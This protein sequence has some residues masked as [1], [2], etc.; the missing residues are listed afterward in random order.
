MKTFE[1]ELR[2][3]PV[4]ATVSYRRQSAIITFTRLNDGVQHQYDGDYRQYQG[5]VKAV[6]A[7]FA[8]DDGKGPWTK[9]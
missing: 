5:S 8:E 3:L 4:G 9:V 6:A 2:N 1:T 7:W